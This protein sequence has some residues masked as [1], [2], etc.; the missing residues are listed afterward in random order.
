[1]K[2]LITNFPRG[3][4]RVTAPR[5]FQWAYGQMLV[6]QGIDLPDYYETHFCNEGDTE[7]ETMIGDSSGVRVP[8]HLLD[9][10]KDVYAYIFLHVEETDGDTE[11]VIRI[12]VVKRPK[13][14]DI[15]PSPEEETVI[16]QLI[17]DLS[18]AEELARTQAQTA[19]AW[20]V[21]ERDGVPV[22]S[23]DETYQ[24]NAKWYA[25][26]AA[27]GAEDAGFAWFDV[28]VSDG[29]MYVTITPDL[30]EDID[31]KVNEQTGHLEVIY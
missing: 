3:E 24:N 9:T 10:G 4:I 30:A 27:Q 31:F 20:A 28:D 17:V 6:I 25:A 26:V 1:M 21:G 29:H 12:P 7:T 19:E 8:D 18:E 14:T 15:E 5:V 13:P 23:S 22:P 2:N 16:G 11:F